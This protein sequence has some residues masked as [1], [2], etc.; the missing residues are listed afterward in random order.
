MH[1]FNAV[2]DLGRWMPRFPLQKRRGTMG[3]LSSEKLPILS[4]KAFLTHGWRLDK[5]DWA[6]KKSYQ[7]VFSV[8][9][10]WKKGGD[11]GSRLRGQGFHNWRTLTLITERLS[12]D[13]HS[14]AVKTRAES[15]ECSLQKPVP[16]GLSLLHTSMDGT[17]NSMNNIYLV[18]CMIW[19]PKHLRKRQS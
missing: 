1:V 16:L 3:E 9:M 4:Q 19:K 18:L 17:S 6:W 7:K 14:S 5:V 10:E 15:T 12:L 8:D 13:N 11:A 2:I